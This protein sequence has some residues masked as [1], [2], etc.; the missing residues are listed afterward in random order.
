MAVR[1]SH[2]RKLLLTLAFRRLPEVGWSILRSVLP[3][4]AK[5]SG[6]GLSMLA[7][8]WRSASQDMPSSLGISGDVRVACRRAI[9][10]SAS[11]LLSETVSPE[12][13]KR[14]M[15]NCR[16]PAA[17]CSPLGADAVEADVGV[18]GE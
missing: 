18:A 4:W 16:T 3:S 17:T 6:S 12:R 1:A 9:M 14:S 7:V 13:W 11:F 5:V 2:L 10:F 15:Q 8:S